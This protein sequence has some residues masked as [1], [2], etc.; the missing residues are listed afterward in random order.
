MAVFN[1]YPYN[2]QYYV[3]NLGQQ[4]MQPQ[5]IQ[6][7]G[8]IPVASE[9]DARSYPVAQGNSVT[10]KDEKLPYVYVKTMGFSQLDRPVFE[11]YRL[12][13]EDAVE[14][15]ISDDSLEANKISDYAFKSD[16]QALQGVVD[17]Y[18]DDLDSVKAE[19]EELNAKISTL[20][21]EIKKK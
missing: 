6:T 18:S 14:S 11:K 13:K 20:K 3:P 17:A 2:Y 8:F 19:I 1:G 7:S 21:K 16:L 9:A 5:Q 12:V 4:N 10:F 15:K